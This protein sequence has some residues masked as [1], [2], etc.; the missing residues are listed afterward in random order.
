M[1]T[2]ATPWRFKLLYDGECPICVRE[3]RWL[4]ARSRDGALALEDISKPN[5]DA[6]QYGVS[7]AE[8]MN[9]LH[10]V[11]PDG[12]MV[13]RVAAVR[14]AYRAVGLGWMVA[15]SEW[16]V[17]SWFFDIGYA[18]FARYRVQIGTLLGRGCEQ[19]TCAVNSSKHA[20]AP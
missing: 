18:L 13:N 3:T 9:V 1:N 12:R 5:F 4:A 2:E 6:A 10:G 8:L 20:P 7:R 16:P 14:E 19:G 11:F 15:P 17:L